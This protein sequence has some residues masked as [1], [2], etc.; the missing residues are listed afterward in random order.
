M[1]ATRH[2][3]VDSVTGNKYQADVA[4]DGAGRQTRTCNTRTDR[5]DRAAACSWPAGAG[6][7]AFRDPSVVFAFCTV[8][9]GLKTLFFSVEAGRLRHLLDF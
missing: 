1:A 2:R 6:P 5:T 7:G 3:L 8:R 4:R 9:A